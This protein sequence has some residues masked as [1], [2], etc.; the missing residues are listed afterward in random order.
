MTVWSVLW[1]LFIWALAAGLLVAFFAWLLIRKGE[2]PMWI[3][4]LLLSVSP[5]QGQVVKVET[6]TT[7]LECTTEAT[8]LGIEFAKAYPGDEHYAY[9]CLKQKDKEA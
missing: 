4:L 1:K 8:R 3:L 7:K 2:I 9:A 5:E 6:Y